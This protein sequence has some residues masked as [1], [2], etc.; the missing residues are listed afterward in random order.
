MDTSKWNMDLREKSLL[1]QGVTGASIQKLRNSGS[2]GILGIPQ[3]NPLTAVSS[4]PLSALGTPRSEDWCPCWKLRWCWRSTSAWNSFS[5]S[6]EW[7]GSVPREGGWGEVLSDR[8][9]GSVDLLQSFY[10]KRVNLCSSM[11]SLS[12][13]PNISNLIYLIPSSW[14][15]AIFNAVRLLAR[16]ENHSAFGI[17]VSIMW[18]KLITLYVIYLHED[19]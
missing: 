2:E 15:Y 11:P 7:G 18:H 5:L 3:T 4:T 17:Y 16:S 13:D 14:P 1:K 19:L 12:R 6:G 9:V 8:W 10:L